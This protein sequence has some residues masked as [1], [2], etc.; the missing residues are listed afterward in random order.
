MDIDLLVFLYIKKINKY[1]DRETIDVHLKKT[2]KST[3]DFKRQ[4]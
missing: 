4:K 3:V 2:T 1:G